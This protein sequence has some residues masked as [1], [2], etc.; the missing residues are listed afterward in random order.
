MRR[1]MKIVCGVTLAAILLAGCKYDAAY[2]INDDGTVS[3]RIL[4]ALYQEPG[5]SPVNDMVQGDADTIAASFTNATITPHNS[6]PWIGYFINF[7]NEPL[8]TFAATPEYTW[9]VRI[10]KSGSNYEVFGYTATDENMTRTSANDNSGYLRVDVYFPGPLI[11]ATEAS[12]SSVNPGWAR[13]DMLT[14]PLNSTPYAKGS[15]PVAAPPAPAPAPVQTV[16]IPP[17]PEP[18][19]T[20]SATPSATPS[21]SPTGVPTV[22]DDNGSSIPVWVWAVGGV[23]LV[24]LASMIGFMVANRKQTIPVAPATKAPA[25]ARAI[26]VEEEPEEDEPEED[27]PEEEKPSPKK[28]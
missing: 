2:T 26:P 21:P 14:I 18:V 7:T 28:K 19:V 24:A 17:A 1:T 5:E 20:P 4:T 6:G 13:F 3:G 10:V 9:D 27:E 16:V 12:E 22:S 23:L 11:E 8:A 15:G 25:K